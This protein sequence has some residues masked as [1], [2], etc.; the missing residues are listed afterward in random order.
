MSN[1]HKLKD[2]LSNMQSA[3]KELPPDHC[4]AL[5]AT[6]KALEAVIAEEEA[7][8]PAIAASAELETLRRKYV[9]TRSHL[10]VVQNH[11]NNE[12]GKLSKAISEYVHAAERFL[13][14]SATGLR[15]ELPPL[16]DDFELLPIW[17]LP[18]LIDC[19]SDEVEYYLVLCPT[20]H[21]WRQPRNGEHHVVVARRKKTSVPA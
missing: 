10:D 19:E 12:C 5:P 14:A 7:A 4:H 6:C 9:E 21:T 8:V 2:I 16:P 15:L 1:V 13:P 11:L 3:M 18:A 20:E 17:N